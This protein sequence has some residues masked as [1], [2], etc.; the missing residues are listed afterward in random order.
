MRTDS[1]HDPYAAF[2]HAAFA[3]VTIGAFVVILG[4]RI[5]AVAILWEVYQRT[6]KYGS[7]GLIGLVQALPMMLLVLPAGHL[8]DH[9]DRVR[10]KRWSLAGATCTSLALGGFSLL[11]GGV[12][13][14][15]LLL[16]LDAAV[17]TLGRPAGQAMLPRLVSRADFANAMMWRSS[18]FQMAAVLGPALGGLV[19]AWRVPAAYFISAATSVLMLILLGRI[20]LR[21]LEVTE[22]AARPAPG[23]QALA[24][25]VGF[26]RREP[27]VLSA[28]S[29]DMFAV[30]LGGAVYLLPVYATDIL[31]VGPRGYGALTAAPALGALAMGVYLAHRR[32]M[33]RAGLALLGAVAGFGAATIVFGLSRNI[34]LS[35]VCL[36]LTGLFDN[37]SVV[38]RHTLIQLRTPDTM[39]GRV[40]ALNSVFI[41]ASNELGGMESGLVAAWFGPVVSVV[42][43]GVG[44][45]L[46]VFGIGAS[47]RTLRGLGSLEVE[48]A[49]AEDAGEP[50]G[51]A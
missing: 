26:L 6:G 37:V 24:E 46:V 48:E 45:L 23:W 44:T 42:S 2:R 4:T 29:L 13:W 5:Q 43:G 12:G 15:Y 35:L 33:R 51:P 16:G 8:A 19:V 21:P 18:T 9:V 41:G 49:G 27:V 25:A 20:R 28:V 36:A 1:P 17:L 47:S 39:R 7:L 31:G 30:L 3:K 22:S 50:P 34:W 38:V 11:E 32:P 40:S 10:I 14:M